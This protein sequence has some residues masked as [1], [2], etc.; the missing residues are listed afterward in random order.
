MFALAVLASVLATGISTAGAQ[1]NDAPVDYRIVNGGIPRPLTNQPGDAERGRHIVLDREG[2]D[3]IICH[4][5]PL[6]QR[7]FHGSIGPP[8]DSVG[9]RSTAGELRL[10]VVDAKVFNPETIMPAY[11]RAQGLYRVRERYRG[12]PVLTAQQVEDIVAYLLTLKAP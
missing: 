3:C 7:Q 2:G 12:I 4:A 11:H 1:D 6:P 9:E 8:L 5:M 10:R